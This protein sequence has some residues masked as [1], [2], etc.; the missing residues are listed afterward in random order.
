MVTHFSFAT[1]TRAAA[2]TGEDRAR[3]FEQDDALIVIVADGAGGVA[4]GAAASD[5]VVDAVRAR[6]EQRPSD[7][8]DVR[9]WS[10]LLVR[11]DAD[12]ARRKS[13]GETTAVIVVVG[14]HGVVGVSVGDSEA[15]MVDSRFD[16]LTD[17]QD[18]ARLGTGRARPK[19]FH[20]RALRGVL[21]AGSDGLFKSTRSEAIAAACSG[22]T[23]IIAERLVELP[24]L[25][26]GAYPDDVAVVVVADPRRTTA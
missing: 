23:S 26:S 19:P 12:L 24:R 6:V 14:P 8:Y 15:W 21:I 1:M 10:D 16:R 17:E 4:G 2:A 20:R 5:A 7:P 18:R 3:V 13:T 11:T 22:A 9:A 25:R